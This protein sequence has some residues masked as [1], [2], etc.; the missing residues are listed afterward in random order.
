VLASAAAGQ[1]QGIKVQLHQGIKVELH[2]GCHK[3]ALIPQKTL[4]KHYLFEGCI[5]LPGLCV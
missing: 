2:Q 3:M 5:L 4:M 1:L